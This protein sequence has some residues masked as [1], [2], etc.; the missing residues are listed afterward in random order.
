MFQG[1]VPTKC[2]RCQPCRIQH[3]QLWT[4]RQ[5]FE[6][7][8]HE[9]STFA[10][11]TF[12]R[13]HN[14]GVVNKKTLRK[15]I[16]RLR[17]SS[18][19]S[20]PYYACGE[21]GSKTNR[22]HYHLSLFGWDIEDLPI[23]QKSWKMGHIQL[24]AFNAATAAYLTGYILKEK[25]A[26]NRAALVNL[27][28]E[29]SSKSPGL[30]KGAMKIIAD[31]LHTTEGLKQLQLEGDVPYKIQIGKRAIYLGTYLRKK[32]REEMGYSPVQIEA[33]NQ[34]FYNE[35]EAQLQELQ[36]TTKNPYADNQE[37]FSAFTRQAAL[38]LTKR[39]AIRK[40]RHL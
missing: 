13:E 7:Y 16:D 36:A 19:N 8:L 15:F 28:P 24:E 4:H 34:R 20:T 30:G 6:S 23:L 14:P 17:S 22:P 11:L 5:I 3:S 31:S 18:G 39:H 27:P 2:G 35:T 33:I 29:F 26:A 37:L 25:T 32:L 40:V 10:T 9:K 12:D 38:N 1:S 21:Y